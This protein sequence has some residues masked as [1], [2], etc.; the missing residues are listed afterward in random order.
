MKLISLIVLL[1]SLVFFYTAPNY[2]SRPFMGFCTIIAI[3][4]IVLQIKGYCTDKEL[5]KIY[6]RHS[7]IFLIFFFIVFF[8]RATDFS[9]G[10]I[11][12]DSISVYD[13]IWAYV[14]SVVSKASA[15][16]LLALSTFLFGYHC[17]SPRLLKDC[18][19]TYK[20]RS[21]YFL[22]TSGFGLLFVYVALTGIGD[23]SKHSED[24]NMG[25]LM[26]AQAV[27]LAIV[28]IYSFVYFAT[29][30]RG[31]A[32]KV[33]L[34]LLASYVYIAKDGVNYKR[35]FV[36]FI[37]GAFSMTLIG[38]IRM[39]ETKKLNEISSLISA[40][41]T[42]SPLTVELSGSVNTVH[43]VLANVPIKQNYNWG[44]SFINGFSVLVPGL[45]RI[46]HGV[47]E[48]SGET[49]TKMYFGENMPDWGWGFGSS[50]IADVYISFGI[51]GIIVI[52]FFLGRFIHYLEYG[53]FV[54]DKS[55]YFLILSFCVF[56]QFH[57][58]CRGSFSI[59]FLSW[60]YAVLL[61]FLFVQCYK[62]REIIHN[63]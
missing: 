45:S 4:L 26:V 60:D 35:I 42:I 33:C 52:F 12:Q 56:S 14:P 54:A 49:I 44:T 17:Y 10:I 39:Q 62:K 24:E 27:L 30:N 21:K 6:L 1:I 38:I 18:I 63:T 2:P 61:V 51:L 34:M 59:L 41:E 16:A 8:Q 50:C 32:I 58:L 40:K 25:F 5:K 7:T 28:V 48:P 36:L 22:V 3:F 53:T 46:T 43:L 19:Y 37:I 57:S 11:D 31:G 9:L 13:L 29:G 55:P 23:F 47:A 15:L 20:F